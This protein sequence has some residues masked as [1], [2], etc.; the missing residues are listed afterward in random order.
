MP[1]AVA[2]SVDPDDADVERLLAGLD[3]SA[4]HAERERWRQNV[5]TTCLPIADHI[6]YRFVGR[7]QSADDLIQVARVGL[8]KSVDR[9]EPEKGRFFAFAVPTIVGEVRRYFRDSTWA[10]R[11]PRK[12]QE[13]H[14]RTRNAF[15][16]LAQRLG[17]T[18][19]TAELAEEAGLE[20]AE[21]TLSRATTWAYRP[22]SLDAP[23]PTAEGNGEQTLAA[24]HPA[25]DEPFAG[26]EDLMMLREAIG[27][28]DARQRTILGMRF[29]DCLTQR[30]IARRLDISQ[31]HVSRLLN[32][33][34][35]RLRT[36]M[37]GDLAAA[38]CLFA[39]IITL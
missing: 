25:D 13:D 24:L 8:I 18:P 15:E 16:R 1:E 32:G 3:G 26:V 27:D 38:V 37:C 29:F 11:V 10:M 31:V 14:L 20:R 7:G 34:L 21:I 2:H 39:P 5:I 28:L 6:A 30:E 17:R 35:D 33:A 22:L 36:R 23:L 9:Y 4:D 12:M 19:T